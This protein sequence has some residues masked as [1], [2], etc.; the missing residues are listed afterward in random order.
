LLVHVLNQAVSKL[1]SLNILASFFI[2][3]N[4]RFFKNSDFLFENRIK[5]SYG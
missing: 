5:R 4:K 3:H 1:T 2:I